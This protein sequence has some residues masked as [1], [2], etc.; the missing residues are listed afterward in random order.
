MMPNLAEI[1]DRGFYTEWG[2]NHAKW[3]ASAE[4]IAQIIYAEYQPKRIVDLGCGSGPYGHFLR[5]LGVSTVEIDGVLPPK[6]EAFTQD[7]EIRDITEPFPNL[8]GNFDFALCLEV[9]EHIPETMCSTFLA[10]LTQ[11]SDRV[12]MSAAPPF[13][14]GTH[15]VNEQP[16]R[17]WIAKMAEHGFAYNRPATGKLI[18][19]FAKDKPGFMWMCSQISVY[20]RQATTS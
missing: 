16:K 10:N 9:A 2:K 6:E 11:F 5:G 17:Y 8:W 4:K 3:V 14:G 20:E 1:Y 13:Q 19:A 18:Q 15:H 12:L 7:I